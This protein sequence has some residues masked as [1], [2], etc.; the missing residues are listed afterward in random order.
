MTKYRG[1]DIKYGWRLEGGQLVMSTEEQ[2]VIA[3]IL[4]LSGTGHSLRQIAQ[5]LPPNRLGKPFH[6][7]QVK[8]IL[9]GQ[10]VLVTPNVPLTAE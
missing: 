1:G 6:A 8:R 7:Q 4:F 10:A 2:R 9:A 3:K 5:R